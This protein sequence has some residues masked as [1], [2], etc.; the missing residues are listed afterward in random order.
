ML[1]KDGFASESSI[2]L[3]N[4]IFLSRSVF[5]FGSW[6]YEADIDGKLQSCCCLLKDSVTQEALD[7]SI[8]TTNQFNSRIF[9]DSLEKPGT[10]L[11]RLSN[12]A[13]SYQAFFQDST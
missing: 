9:E 6:V 3:D 1:G 13:T 12:A 2:D 10:F 11:F 7:V 5:I 8:T 4:M